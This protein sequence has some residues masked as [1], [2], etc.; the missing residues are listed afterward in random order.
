MMKSILLF[1]IVGAQMF[2]TSDKFSNIG[3]C[4]NPFLFFFFVL[5]RENN[6]K[7]STKGK[8]ISCVNYVGHTNVFKRTT[9]V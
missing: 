2:L 9:R 7:S 4:V 8:L 5:P 1:L 3:S 6:C